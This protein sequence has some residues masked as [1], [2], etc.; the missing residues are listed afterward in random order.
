MDTLVPDIRIS[1]SIRLAYVML[2]LAADIETQ[3]G[4]H[5]LDILKRQYPDHAAEIDLTATQIGHIMINAAKKE[6]Q[7]DYAAAQDAVQDFLF[8]IVKRSDKPEFDFKA[9]TRG[10]R[11]GAKTWKAALNN[12]L[13]NIRTTA[14]STSMR[15]WKSK[16]PPEQEY[17]DL[18]FKKQN[19]REDSKK[20]LFLGDPDEF[21]R[22]ERRFVKPWTLKDD[23]RL[24]ELER[25]IKED[26]G[27]ISKIKPSIGK[28]K[29]HLDKSIDD[30]FGTRGEDG[31]DP[32]GGEARIPDT[33]EGI[34][35]ALD[36]KVAI[37]EFMDLLNAEI[38][39]L[40]KTLSLDEDTLFDLIFYED[41]G[42]LSS[43]IKA[44]MGQ[45]SEFKDKLM[46]TP[47]GQAI[48]QKNEKRWSGYVG[49]LRKKL[50]V[51]INDFVENTLS[52]AQQQVLYDTFFSDTTEGALEE[53]EQQ[54]EKGKIDYQR[55]IDERK[56]ARWKW[57]IQNKGPLNEKNQK[58]YTALVRKLQSEGVDANSIE[59][60]EDPEGSAK[61]T[62]GLRDKRTGGPE[63]SGTQQ[64][65]LMQIAARV[66]SMNFC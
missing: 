66:A 16:L 56:V 53:A 24:K 23:K 47:E 32:A 33:G 22:A 36:D 7:G 43:D 29:G 44:N 63:I 51:K 52:P 21:G 46:Q 59:P 38:P 12:M 17:A 49:D 10:G 31:G 30:A 50:L 4:Q 14:M 28:Y 35:G 61:T 58:S 42:G 27:D 20:K 34:G 5:I 48:V 64:A 45:A 9:P 18:L 57:E 26:G 8:K 13:S 40:R 65:S 6:L 2:R 3:M 19:Q 39:N 11:P 55:G 62:K 41:I 15:N 37:K 60:N 54:K 25:Q 1:A